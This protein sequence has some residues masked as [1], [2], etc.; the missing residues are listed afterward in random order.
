MRYIMCRLLLLLMV[1]PLLTG[2]SAPSA[3]GRVTEKVLPMNGIQTSGGYSAE[4]LVKDVFAKGACDNITNV[5]AIGSPEGIGFFENGTSSVGMDKGII[6]ATGSIKHAEGPNKAGDKSG[7][8]SNPNG[9]PDLAMLSTHQILDAQG[10]EFDFTPLDS[11]VRFRYVFAS[12]EYCEFV[13]S[14]YNDV[15]GF[16]V[17]GPG[18]QGP[19]SRNS[20]NVA[21]IPGTN[22]YVA[23]NSVN[24][25]QNPNYFIRNELEKDSRQCG[26]QPFLSPYQQLIEYDGFTKILTAT[27]KVIPCETY[28]I[29]FVVSDVADRHYDSAV[30]L[31]AGS[32]N[33]GGTVAVKA[34]GN[35]QNVG[36][37]GCMP[38][39]FV[40]ERGESENL[41]KP[42]SVRFKI[43]NSS[44]AVE[45][46]DFARL[47]RTITIPPG[48][49]SFRLPIE[50]INDGI[51][52]SLEKLAIELD[53]P[54][55]C[56]SS[57]ATL[58]IID[59]PKLQI[60]L[61]E[62]YVCRN[63]LANLQPR[64]NG[65]VP[66]YTYEWSNGATTPFISV[67]SGMVPFYS[68]TV[69]DQ[70]GNVAADTTSLTPIEPPAA[71]L[72]GLANSCAG[73][74]ALLPIQIT[75]TPPF[76]VTYSIN[77]QIQPALD[78]VHQGT[79]PH[80]TAYLP[81]TQSGVYKI[82]KIE[83]AGCAGAAIGSAQVNVVTIQIQ[84]NI[85]SVTCANGNDGSI[86][87]QPNGGTPPY[88]FQWSHT[89]A[90]QPYVS[91]LKANTYH[92][93]VTDD[94]GCDNTFPFLVNEPTP[95]QPVVF[96]CQDLTN[97]NFQFTAQGGTPPYLYAIDGVKY[98]D[99]SIF[100][101]LEPGKTYTLHIRDAED[102]ELQHTLTMPPV[103]DKMVELPAALELNLGE[104]YEF[105]PKLNLAP[106]LIAKIEW[107]SNEP[108]SCTDCLNPQIE[109]LQEGI[110][111]LKI[112]DIFGC[113][114]KAAVQVSIDPDVDVYI[115]T[116]FSPNGDRIND[117]FTIYANT[118]Q[119][120]SILSLFIFDRWGNQIFANTNFYPNDERSGWDGYVNGVI[121]NDGV[122]VYSAILELRDGSKKIVKGQILLI[123]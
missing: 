39:A 3:V 58:D 63:T 79:A 80:F 118:N 91:D 109:A 100:K 18:I 102:C 1:I 46:V 68:V 26:I 33:I 10:I 53:I 28:H 96:N 64:V 24:H 49:Q 69:T 5:R 92:V 81:A 104:V 51:T 21:L 66:P 31:E 74:T 60:N 56:Y 36:M 22:A 84:S 37:E 7:N 55:A 65:G 93:T 115:P 123:R 117:F 19:F 122:Y 11:F 114:D 15:F 23:I 82:I 76:R 75:G 73:D 41:D 90:N 111:T 97:P 94:Q 29:R 40:F 103:Y 70:C 34:L 89:T 32:F 25:I 106:N 35:Q 62:A 95:L 98:S 48:E 4:S 20:K 38:A 54:C 101:T 112:T 87:I 14:V 42:L 45:G 52:E 88:H 86:S 121:P 67:T 113:T 8:F 44:T 72:S 78:L 43:S 50:I 83:D 61:P 71:T 17:S 13:G 85:Q 119:V 77:D 108:L 110:Y 27:L 2:S 30:F 120:K 6:I 116:A 16:F 9:D 12:E 105:Q 57:G 47:P 59:A 99:A 107:Q